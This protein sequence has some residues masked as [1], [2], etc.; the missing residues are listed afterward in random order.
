[1]SS[2]AT[3][4]PRH[5][6]ASFVARAHALLDALD[7]RPLWPLTDTETAH[8]LRE[9]TRLAAH[10]DR[11]DIGAADGATSAAMWWAHQTRQTPRD[12]ASKMKLAKGVEQHGPVAEAL[13]GGDLLLAGPGS[14]SRPSTPC[15]TTST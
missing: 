7:D 8:T 4:T 10:A 13:A 2:S 9:A 5:P 6:I 3:L 11:A 1:M 12:A 14:S 15:P